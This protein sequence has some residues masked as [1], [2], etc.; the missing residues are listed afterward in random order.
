MASDT[1][2]TVVLPAVNDD[3]PNDPVFM[4]PQLIRLDDIDESGRLRPVD[5]VVASGIAA[6]M[7]LRGQLQPVDICQLPNQASGKPYRLVFGGHRMAA[8]RLAGWT[9]I[10][11]FIRSNA[12]LDRMSREIEENLFKA[13]LSPLD[14]AAFVR[15]L[16]ETEKARLG[17]ES[18]ADGRALNSDYRSGKYQKKQ[19][20]NDLCTMH[21]SLGLQ[22]AVAARLGLT[23]ATVSRDLSLNGIA[24]SFLDR[25]RALPG[26]A[27]N[28]SAL[29]K[30]AGLHWTKQAEVLDELESGQAKNVAQ[31]VAIVTKAVVPDPAKKRMGTFVG[32]FSRMGRSEK[33]A[34]LM[35]LSRMMPKGVELVFASAA[36]KVAAAQEAA[37]LI[38]KGVVEA[39]DEGDEA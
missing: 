16:I 13:D 35:A 28:A 25:V 32:T 20:T 36:E 27:G 31:A 21:K 29:R 14:R 26:L 30:L 37:Q 23:Q 4:L 7:A 1:P 39:G 11:A 34:A 5:S 12:A 18:G 33:M 19:L 17:I 2:E 10:Q 9:H 38:H 22:E 8:A 6:S 15:E 3:A 24:P